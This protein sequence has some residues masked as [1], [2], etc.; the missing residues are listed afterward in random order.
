MNYLDRFLEKEGVGRPDIA[1]PGAAP[2]VI[3]PANPVPST[4]AAWLE[5]P[6]AKPGARQKWAA[7]PPPKP[8]KAG[9]VP[10]RATIVGSAG[11]R[12]PHPR[13]NRPGSPSGLPASPRAQAG[14][15][16]PDPMVVMIGDRAFEYSVYGGGKLAAGLLG[17]DTETALIE[18]VEV[19]ELVLA[20]ASSGDDHRLIH[21]DRLGEFI[22]AHRSRRWVCHNAAFDFW[23]VADHLAL[24][25]KPKAL[26]AWWDIAEAG[27]MHDTMILDGMIRLGRTDAYPSPRDLAA[28]AMEHAGLEVDKSD[29]FRLRYGEI[30]GLDWAAVERGFFEYAIKDPIVTRLAYEVMYPRAIALMEAHGYVPTRLA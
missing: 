24:R 25:R 17:F 23:V 16:T 2:A 14:T 20:A 12:P 19:P 18:G 30:I 5:N 22:L 11:P 7:Q 9:T 15:G 29:P 8:A 1:P 26:K 28:V 27:R 3:G 4:S 13:V 6:P 10:V 21:P